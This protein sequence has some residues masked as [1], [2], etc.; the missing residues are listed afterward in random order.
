MLDYVQMLKY[1]LIKNN[2]KIKNIT[3]IKWSKSKNERVINTFLIL[4]IDLITQRTNQ[5][6]CCI[7]SIIIF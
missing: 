5:I 6:Y 1:L 4:S 3:N 2:Q 7:Q